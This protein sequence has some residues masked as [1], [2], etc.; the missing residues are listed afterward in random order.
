MGTVVRRVGLGSDFE[1]FSGGRFGFGAFIGPAFGWYYPGSSRYY[2]SRVGLLAAPPVYLEQGGDGNVA[3]RAEWYY[4]A[5]SKTYYPY[6]QQCPAE[7]RRIPA[8]PPP[9]P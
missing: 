3:P 8:Q 9:N 6:V 2:P 4:C 1:R 5:E 7:W